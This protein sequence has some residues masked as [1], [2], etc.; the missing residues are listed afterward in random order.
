MA[1]QKK[2]KNPVDNRKPKNSNDANRANKISKNGMRDAAT[3]S[4]ELYRFY[5]VQRYTST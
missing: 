2:G 4:I 3:V 5:G 1:K